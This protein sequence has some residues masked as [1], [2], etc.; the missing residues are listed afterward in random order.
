MGAE[1][2]TVVRETAEAVAGRKA[3]LEIAKLQAEIVN[4]RR[5]STWKGVVERNVSFFAAFISV[6]GLAVGL[7]QFNRQQVANREQAK[8]Q[9]AKEELGRNE[10]LRKAYWQEQKTVYSQGSRYAGIIASAGSLNQV[11]NETR[12]FWGLYWGTMSLLEHSEVE[13]AM[14]AFGDAV[15]EW[16]K[17]NQ[18]PAGIENLSYQLAHCMKQSLAKTWR[19]VSGGPEKD[20]ACPY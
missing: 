19:P 10:E 20:K 12:E 7:W 5:S 17:R 6:A 11:V 8:A 2:Q 9:A 4:L 18:K 1:D 16:Q 13:K 14:M 3:G 15:V